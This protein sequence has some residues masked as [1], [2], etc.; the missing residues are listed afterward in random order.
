MPETERAPSHLKNFGREKVLSA[1]KE[2]GKNVVTV[3][4]T[5]L[6]HQKYGNTV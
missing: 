1:L 4:V 2:S 3:C 5:V 6:P